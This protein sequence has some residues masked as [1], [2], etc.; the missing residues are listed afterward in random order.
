[1]SVSERVAIVSFAF[2]GA[3]LVAVVSFGLATAGEPS[4]LWLWSDVLG[5]L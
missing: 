5:V 2:V 1:M 3:V 4:A